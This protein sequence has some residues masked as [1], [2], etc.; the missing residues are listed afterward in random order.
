MDSKGQIT[1]KTINSNQN[2][3][4]PFCKAVFLRIHNMSNGSIYYSFGGSKMELN[5]WGNDTYPSPNDPM[6]GTIEFSIPKA[7]TNINI[8][9]FKIERQ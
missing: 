5:A 1:T 7:T 9:I 3:N 8:R 2:L 4:F 6:T